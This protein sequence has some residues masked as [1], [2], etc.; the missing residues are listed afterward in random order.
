VT[1][2]EAKITRCCGP[3][4]C[5]KVE[6]TDLVYNQ[7]DTEC[8][9]FTTLRFC[10]GNACMAWRWTGNATWDGYCGLAGQS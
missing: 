1:E 8:V 2:D 3:E 4:G 9:G 6:R 5:G 10:V 7:A